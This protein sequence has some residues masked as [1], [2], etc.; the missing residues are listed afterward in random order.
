MKQINFKQRL[1][2]EPYI[3]VYEL[4]DL[5]THIGQVKIGYTERK[6]V[7]QRIHEQV[8]VLGAIKYNI[9]LETPAIKSDGST[10]TESPCSPNFTP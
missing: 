1:E 5:T 8:R 2:T 7:Q 3:Y 6:T 10:F 4:P 9:L